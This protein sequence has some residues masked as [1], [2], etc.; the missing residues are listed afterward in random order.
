MSES[1]APTAAPGSTQ[2]PLTG[3]GRTMARRMEAAWQAPVFH[4]TAEAD[5]KEWHGT[6]KGHDGATLTDVLLLRAARALKLHPG[7]NAHYDP[8]ELAV[9][10]FERVDIGLAVAT[11]RGLLVPVLRGV[12]ALSLEAIAAKRRALVDRARSGQLSA[13]EMQ[14]ATF[15]VSNLGMFSVV[16]FDAIL[17]VPQVA[18]LAV[19]AVQSRVVLVGGEIAEKRVMTLTLTCD[20]RAVDGATGATFLRDLTGSP[21]SD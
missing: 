5:A 14:G 20:H 18:I 21:D 11:E 1:L 6:R 15:T 12:E 9:I 7:L 2:V 17:N 4:L 13:A 8:A 16:Q 10:R 3:T 19:G